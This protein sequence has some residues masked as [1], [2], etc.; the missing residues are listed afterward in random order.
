THVFADVRGRTPVVDARGAL[1]PYVQKAHERGIVFDLG[2]GGSSFVFSQAIPAIRQKLLP[3][4]VSTDTHRR[5]RNGS[6][7]DLVAVLSKLEALGVGLPDLIRRSSATPADVIDR[8]ELGRLSEGGVADI[9]V[10]GVESGRFTF[11]DV[12]GAR[13]EGSRRLSCELTLRAG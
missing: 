10:L 6:M 7:Q 4:T 11:T 5:S 9:A 2:Y 13:V 8:P 1:R 12:K 3:D